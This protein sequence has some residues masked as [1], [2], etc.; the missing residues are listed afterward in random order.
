MIS[1]GKA[2]LAIAA[3]ATGTTATAW[4]SSGANAGAF[5]NCSELTL[6]VVDGLGS[7]ASDFCTQM[8]GVKQDFLTTP[9]TVNTSGG[10]FAR[11]DWETSFRVEEGDPILDEQ[12]WTTAMNYGEFLV[13]FKGGN[14]NLTGFLLVPPATLSWTASPLFFWEQVR[15]RF[16][17]LRNPDIS[18]ITFYGRG[19]PI[20]A[21]MSASASALG[22]LLGGLAVARR[23]MRKA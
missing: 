13:T 6:S 16:N 17:V 3:L 11:D 21:P 8:N 20:E 14:A 4:E 5:I 9:L 10:F 18:H 19:E 1:F 12:S 7:P 22:L 15:K 23:R 2:L